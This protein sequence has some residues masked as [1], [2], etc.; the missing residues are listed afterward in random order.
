MRNAVRFEIDLKSAEVYDGLGN[1]RNYF[2]G[3]VIYQRAPAWSEIGRKD[4]QA[5]CYK[6]WQLEEG[7]ALTAMSGVRCR[8]K[9]FSLHAMRFQCPTSWKPLHRHGPVRLLEAYD[10]NDLG[11]AEPTR[12]R[13][14][15][16]RR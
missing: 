13:C 11:P 7:L 2:G 10:S 9:G 15:L 4:M 1:E 5:K 16:D 6:A 14:G 3:E 8:E 12:T